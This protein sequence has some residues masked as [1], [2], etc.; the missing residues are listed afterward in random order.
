MIPAIPKSLLPDTMEVYLADEEAPHRGVYLE[1]VTV[2]GVRFEQAEALAVS[3][4]ALT[5]GAS[6]RIWIDARNSKGAMEVP[7][8][9]KIVINCETLHVLTCST[10]KAGRRVHHWELDV[11]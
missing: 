5:D 2:E 3:D 4:Y 6:G 9:S 1:P 10:Y 7:P 8:G 11:A